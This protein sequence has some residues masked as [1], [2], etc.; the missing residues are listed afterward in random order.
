MPKT[1]LMQLISFDIQ[2]VLL[3][4]PD[5]N[6]ELL[7]APKKYGEEDTKKDEEVYGDITIVAIKPYD[8]HPYLD[9]SYMAFPTVLTFFNHLVPGR[10]ASSSKR[11][12]VAAPSHGLQD[13]SVGVH[14]ITQLVHIRT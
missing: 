1:S 11:T 12:A 10:T 2:K 9:L 3:G 7:P 6:Y 5:C 8:S 14:C 4:L 13:Y